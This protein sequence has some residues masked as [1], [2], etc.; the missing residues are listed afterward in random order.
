MRDLPLP[1]SRLARQHCVAPLPRL[2]H[3]R[4]A[5]GVGLPR[6]LQEPLHSAPARV[7][8][9]RRVSCHGGDGQQHQAVVDEA[10][11]EACG[12]GVGGVGVGAAGAAYLQPHAARRSP[13]R[14]PGQPR[15]HPAAPTRIA[16]HGAV[17]RTL[18]EVHAINRIR[19]RRGHGA[20]HVAGVCARTGMGWG[21][22]GVCGRGRCARLRRAL[23]L[24]G[25]VRRAPLHT[26]VRTPRSPPHSS[27]PNPHPHQCT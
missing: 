24:R 27:T 9:A 25:A 15:A 10:R 22:G 5:E 23:A 16:R 1:P 21:C 13:A 17:H 8:A 12:G 4:I 14:R 18:R 6:E 26:A 19:R 20:D 7:H 11:G 3:A 2:P